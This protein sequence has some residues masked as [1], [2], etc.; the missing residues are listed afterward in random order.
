MQKFDVKKFGWIVSIFFSVA[1]VVSYVWAFTLAP[2]LRELYVQLFQI[3]YIRFSGLNTVSF[4]LG[5]V[6]SFI[7]GWLTALVFGWIWNRVVKE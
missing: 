6:Q 1:F 7:C 4:I 3:Q 5:L 2:S